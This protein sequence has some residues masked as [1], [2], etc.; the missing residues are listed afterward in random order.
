MPPGHP[1]VVGH[2][3]LIGFIRKNFGNVQSV[4]LSDWKVI[5]EGGLAVVTTNVE[6]SAEAENQLSESMKQ[7]LVLSKDADGKWLVKAVIFN[8]GV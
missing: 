1:R 6:W 8:T 5:G 7:M 3:A 2:D 4:T